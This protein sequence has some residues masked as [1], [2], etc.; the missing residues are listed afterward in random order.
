[1]KQLKPVKV[2]NGRER[3]KV[4]ENKNKLSETNKNL[5]K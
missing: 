5:P 3:K 1:M 2:E 4:R